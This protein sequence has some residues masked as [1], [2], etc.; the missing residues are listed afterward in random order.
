MNPNSMPGPGDSATWPPHVRRADPQMESDD[1]LDPNEVDEWANAI[2]H[3]PAELD[4]L[5]SGPLNYS[6][7]WVKV[8][9]QY[10][11]IYRAYEAARLRS[12]AGRHD[13]AEAILRDIT[14]ALLVELRRLIVAGK[15]DRRTR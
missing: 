10:A 13:E 1:P 7:L 14:Q 3:D 11:S 4:A 8:D 9:G 5:Q 12:T 15:I 6:L 2:T